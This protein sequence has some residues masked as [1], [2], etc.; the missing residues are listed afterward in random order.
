MPDVQL[1]LNGRT[2]P[3]HYEH[4]LEIIE[5]LDNA[6]KYSR[7]MA[8]AIVSLGVPS[9]TLRLIYTTDG[10]LDT[11]DLDAL[12]ATGDPVIRRGVV[13]CSEF[14][15]ML[16]DAQA[17]D[18]L[19]ADDFELLESMARKAG[20]LY[21]SGEEEPERRLSP[22]MAD[23][24]L[25]HIAGSR[26]PEL[27][28]LL[29]AGDTTPPRFCLSFRECLEYGFSADRVIPTILPGDIELLGSVSVK[30]L[31]DIARHVERIKNDE[32]R[33]AVSH[34]LCAHPDP[35]VR[36]ALAQCASTPRSNLELLLKDSEPDVRLAARQTLGLDED[37]TSGECHEYRAHL[38]IHGQKIPVYHRH[39][40]AI[41][42]H[43]PKD[44][45]HSHE[46]AKALV[47]LGVPSVTM[48]LLNSSSVA[49]LEHLDQRDLDELW[50]AGDLTIRR[51]L[52]HK[53]DYV[54]LLSDAQAQDI[55]DA[56]DPEMLASMA[57][58]TPL[59]Y[60]AR[61]EEPERRLSNAM[62]D[63]L[64]EY[65]ASSRS[66]KLPQTLAGNSD[67][68]VKFRPSFR[69]CVESNYWVR[70]V[71]FAIQP[72]DI[73]LLSTVSVGTLQALAY[74]LDEIR[75]DEARREVI[76]ALLVHPDPAVRLKLAQNEH[77]VPRP[78]LELLLHDP[79]PDVALYASESLDDS[80]E[81]LERTQRCRIP[82]GLPERMFTHSENTVQLC[83]KGQNFPVHYRFLLTIAKTVPRGAHYSELVTEFMALGVPSITK[84]LIES[85]WVE[86]EP[87]FLDELWAVG[88][89]NIRKSL[90]EN[91]DFLG[92]LTDAQ[93]RDILDIEDRE[94]FESIAVRNGQIIP[95]PGHWHG[96]DTRL[97]STMH[98]T[99]FEHIMTSRYPE[100]RRVLAEDIFM[101]FH[102]RPSFRE[103]VEAGFKVGRVIPA[104]QPEDI[105]LLNAVSL[106]SLQDIARHVEKIRNDEA[107]R[108]VIHFLCT[109]SDPSVR[110]ALARNRRAPQAVLESLLTDAEPDVVLAAGKSLNHQRDERETL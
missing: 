52:T 77:S 47:A 100:A 23:A 73:E 18:I 22:A 110:L 10:L 82:G 85:P 86:L 102:F 6:G 14:V 92:W 35:S 30:T 74:R 64:L 7:A 34:F 83:I 71:F 78:V 104:I 13:L 54:E 59:L 72:A 20:L 24:L 79:E 29:A 68:P 46:V 105:P 25:E 57:R 1:I 96:Y 106:K 44:G 31:E 27:R 17:Q 19:D 76:N 65:I 43:L 45:A 32:A 99:L 12:W 84:R 26:Y 15:K 70:N 33:R 9:L 94:M 89:L 51:F 3:V 8:K 75:N 101:P 53:W 81:N 56:D 38:V 37:D 80:P 41:A 88:D 63:A 93:A 50:A 28:Q 2:V 62:A 66:P 55:I 49:V 58:M 60:A 39:L 98:D 97:S 108:E 91:W 36:L 5:R 107:R 103:C 40:L 95:S 21:P 90:A 67:S 69:E 61:K 42:E 48:S 11:Q 4:F 87:Q 109:H 16:T